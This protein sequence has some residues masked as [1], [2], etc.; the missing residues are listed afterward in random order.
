V[1][2]VAENYSN[3]MYSLHRLDVAKHLFYPS[4][5]TAAQ[6]QELPA[7]APSESLASIA[8]AGG[9]GGVPPPPTETLPELVACT[10]IES[11][12]QLGVDRVG[13]HCMNHTLY[14][15]ARPWFC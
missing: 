8:G 10:V 14:L 3:N 6:A 1:N 15:R 11:T 4:T 7:V 5:T 12:D 2:I 9:G 13:E